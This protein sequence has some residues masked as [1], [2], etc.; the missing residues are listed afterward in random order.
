MAKVLIVDDEP[1]MRKGVRT[2][3]EKYVPEVDEIK[4]AVSGRAAIE[5]VTFL[6]PDIVCMDIKMSGIDGIET[7]RMIR[8]LYPE[9]AVIVISA[10]DEFDTAAK[11]M[12]YGIE[13]Y[14]V[15]PLD[16]NE[17]VKEIDKILEK[18]NQ[19]KK[20]RTDDM[21]IREHLDNLQVV[22][23]N[24]LTY[25]FMMGDEDRIDRL[26]RIEERNC[27]SAGG[28]AV[29]IRFCKME[30]EPFQNRAV[31]EKVIGKLKAFYP[32]DKALI[33]SLFQNEILIFLFYNE[34]ADVSSWL[35]S[36]V[37]TIRRI[38]LE[39]HADSVCLGA[40]SC[41]ESLSDMQASYCSAQNAAMNR[42]DKGVQVF[43][44][45][46][47][48]DHDADVE[49]AEYPLE[50]EH[51][52]MQSIEALNAEEALVLFEGFIERLMASGEG[53]LHFRHKLH[54]FAY[55]LIHYRLR[56][57]LN[58]QM[59]RELDNESDIEFLLRWCRFAISGTVEELR[60]M[61]DNAVGT[62]VD[63]EKEYIREHFAEALSLTDAAARANVSMYYYSR[64][65]KARTG[66]S[67]VEY[68]TDYRIHLAKEMI[69]KNPHLKTSDIAEK[70][71]YPDTKYFSRRFSTLVGMSPAAFRDEVI[72]GGNV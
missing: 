19:S 33:S 41:V 43:W 68:L 29:I 11:I 35:S 31:Y 14:L 69:R 54:I 42:V 10:Y 38:L 3:L 36:Q 56:N 61:R 28:A 48:A 57:K 5:Q 66:K 46:V 20:R 64:V 53:C 58:S 26:L 25:S 63:R 50:L 17:F 37:I 62:I 60:N 2:I 13:A 51:G 27:I 9:A 23:E 44:G 22:Y 21:N 59:G 6:H 7:T 18:K 32:K 12:K 71:G 45:K 67:F 1:I 8:M 52:I 55:R 65:F 34:D 16:R 4:E 39:N 47:S 40:G 30:K 49:N 72:S 24:E 70:V 15:K